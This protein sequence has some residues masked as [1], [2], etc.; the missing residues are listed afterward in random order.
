[1]IWR[2][3]FRLLVQQRMF[4]P[5]LVFGAKFSR[6]SLVHGTFYLYL[7]LNIEI[8]AYRWMI[9]L[10]TRSHMFFENKILA[11]N[12]RLYNLKMAVRCQ[13]MQKY[14]LLFKTQTNQFYIKKTSESRIAKSTHP[15][16]VLRSQQEESGL[17]YPECEE[18]C[19]IC[20]ASWKIKCYRVRIASILQHLRYLW[21]K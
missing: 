17:R 3:I 10:K 20:T 2:E 7:I 4:Y 21:W 18:L 19:D 15:R 9:N 5:Y 1:M 8:R 13:Y 14:Y 12:G 6:H 11:V 16:E